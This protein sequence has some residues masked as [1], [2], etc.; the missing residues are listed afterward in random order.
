VSD[1]ARH[2]GIA[3]LG[4]LASALSGRE[5]AVEPAAPGAAAWTDGAVI[6][7]GAADFEAQLRELCVQAAL[8]A[9]G[10]LERGL[11]LQ[12]A[13]RP[14]AC[15]RYLAVEG[16]RALAALQA[17][18]P[19]PLQPLIDRA[20]AARCA[21]AADALALALGR[22]A[23]PAAPPCFGTIRPRELLARA[24][25]SAVGGGRHLP[26][27]EPPRPPEELPED[28]AGEDAED[29]SSPVGG[30]GG[31]GRLLQKLFQ[32]V[33]RLSEG[34]PPGADAVSH[35]T[36]SR[37]RFAVA[38]L[39]SAPA[40]EAVA[41]A[42]GRGILYP[43]WDVHRGC[44]R[45]DWCTVKE[46]EPP[47]DRHANVAWLE[48]QGLRRPLAR[49][50][51]G[52]E[53]RRRCA[54]GDDIDL[55]AAIEARLRL[56]SGAAPDEAVYVESLRRRRDLSVLILLDISGSVT[57]ASPAGGKVHEQQRAAAAALTT[58]LYEIGDRV[59]LY[60]F[61]SQGRHAVDLVPVKRFD[62][63]LDSRVMRR[64][65][66]L[67]PGAYSRLGTAIRHGATALIQRGGTARRL[68]LVLS[69]GLA[70]DHGY[71]PAYGAADARQAL[72]EARRDGV[73][74]VCLSVG[75]STDAASLRRVFGSAAHA[76]TPGAG[77]V[78]PCLGP[79]VQAALRNA[80]VR[81]RIA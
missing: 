23:L 9:A 66:G 69:D 54:Q 30:S 49:L 32:Q 12:L 81:R 41:D 17:V 13:R 65:H 19:P 79:L 57:Q 20:L 73:G 34:G 60:A 35:W 31:L 46:T 44:Y 33:R 72:A 18:L 4:L 42:F 55:D 58:V 1:P 53:R 64:L 51:L 77:Q 63:N 67:E 75:A 2:P 59:A 76:S 56:L 8:L 43:E 48:G 80:E 6:F 36:R 61:H 70:Y 14:A 74:C 78:G 38:S 11:V 16:H 21:S 27:S 29:A 25:A 62:D 10:S 68:L 50:G 7:I 5:L 28:A 40:A 47:A 52:L 45:P 39:S 22:E 3:R 15:G 37:P 71:D 24:A 26:R